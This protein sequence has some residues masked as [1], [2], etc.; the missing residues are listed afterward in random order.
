[1]AFEDSLPG[2]K[3]ATGAGIST[4]GM[5]TSRTKAALVEAGVVRT[6]SDFHDE[7]MWRWLLALVA[8]A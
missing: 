3:S 7:G 6:A 4:V 8:S 1:V 5:L 2:V